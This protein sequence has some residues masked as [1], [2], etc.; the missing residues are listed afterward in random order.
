MEINEGDP[1]SDLRPEIALGWRRSVMSG[2]D[3]GMEVRESRLFDVDRHS[4]L[5][6]ACSPILTRLVDE[7]NDTRFSILLA[8]HSARIVDRRVANRMI[9]RHLD[10]VKAVP[11]ARYLEEVSGTNSLATAFETR[12]PIAVA[13]DEHF[14]EALRVF[15][16]YGAPIIHPITRRLEGVIDVTGPLEDRNSL[17]GP[18]VMRAVRDIELR[19]QEGSR[20]SERLLFAEFQAQTARSKSAVMVFGENLALS[21]AAAS[22]LI[23]SDDHPILRALAGEIGS[24]GR[25]TRTVALSSGRQV[26]VHARLIADSREGVLIELL[27]RTV[28]PTPTLPKRP[29]TQRSPAPQIVLVTGEPGSGR[30]TRAREIAGPAARLIDLADTADPRQWRNALA[31]PDGVVLDNLHLADSRTAALLRAAL[32]AAGGTVVLIGATP[33]ELSVEHRALLAAASV[34]EERPNL[35]EAGPEFPGIVRTLLA[36]TQMRVAPSTMDLLSEQ[37]WPG[38]LTEL[39]HV[40]TSARRGRTRGDITVDDLPATHRHRSTRGL[41]PLERAERATI[42]AALNATNGNKLAAATDLGIGRN[43]LYQRIKYY[44]LSR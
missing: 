6:R 7:L 34:H 28:G 3:P 5:L 29:A 18:F 13:G 1:G 37:D 22:D 21:N 8:D 20:Q 25:I 43:T 4:R 17:L 16:C 14:L 41:T 39:R 26:D 40:L 9:D 38:N 11:G 12:K 36:D 10:R 24:G 31:D 2:L 42:V 23:G 32:P 35:R 19:L 15:C 30:S 27:P 33:D 44:G